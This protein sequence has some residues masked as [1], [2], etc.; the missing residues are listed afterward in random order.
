MLNVYYV[1][2]IKGEV[3][4]PVCLKTYLETCIVTVSKWKQNIYFIKS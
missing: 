4:I 1:G 3:L 2:E